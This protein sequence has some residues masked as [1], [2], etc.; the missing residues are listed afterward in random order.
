M[1]NGMVVD[2]EVQVDRPRGRG[3]GTR[4]DL[5]LTAARATSTTL[6]RVLVEAKRVDNAGLLTALQDQ[7]VARYLEPLGLTHGLY[8]VYWIRSEQRPPGWS[9]SAARDMSELQAELTQQAKAVTRTL[10]IEV[11]VYVLDVSRPILPPS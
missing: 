7:L 11:I 9:R 1:N 2:R 5:T 8:L 3:I 10:G 4:I 6:A